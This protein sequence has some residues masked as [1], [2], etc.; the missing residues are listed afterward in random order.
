M[1]ST[2]VRSMGLDLSA[3]RSGVTVSTMHG[4]VLVVI[5]KDS[6]A[7]EG[8]GFARAHRIAQ[9]VAALIHDYKPAIVVIEGYAYGNAFSLA[10][11]VEIGTL[12]RLA[13]WQSGLDYLEPAP[14]TLKKFVTGSGQASKEKM[15]LE[16]FKRWG[17]EVSNHDEADSLGLSAM[18]LAYLNVMK[19][20]KSGLDALTICKSHSPK[21]LARVA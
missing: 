17:I 14:A 12:V 9:A 8:K 11:L 1:M 21:S 10:T 5:F 7:I 16:V 20:P 6:I 19:V 4:D 13:V 3:T 15:V 18:G 2:S